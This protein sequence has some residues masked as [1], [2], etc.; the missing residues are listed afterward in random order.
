M[1]ENLAADRRITQKT[2]NSVIVSR[3]IYDG[4]LVHGGQNSPHATVSH[5][6]FISIVVDTAS[7]TE[8][9]SIANLNGLSTTD[10]LHVKDI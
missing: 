6:L 1:N 4:Y 3:I 7:Y 5:R 9:S 8:L 2:L 10:I